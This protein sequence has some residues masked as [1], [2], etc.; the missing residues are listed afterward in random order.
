MMT[1][2]TVNH[3]NPILE[4]Q[5]VVMA[6]GLADSIANECSIPDIVGLVWELL[7]HR[8][9]ECR[10]TYVQLVDALVRD[11]DLVMSVDIIELHNIGERLRNGT[12]TRR[13]SSERPNKANTSKR[14][15]QPLAEMLDDE[16]EDEIDLDETR[17]HQLATEDEVN[18]DEVDLD[19]PLL[20]ETKE[21]LNEFLDNLPPLPSGVT[22]DELARRCAPESRHKQSSFAMRDIPP[23]QRSPEELVRLRLD[24]ELAKRVVPESRKRGEFVGIVQGRLKRSSDYP[25]EI[26]PPEPKSE[27]VSAGSKGE[28][29][30]PTISVTWWQCPLCR[31]AKGVHC[32]EVENKGT[33]Y[34]SNCK[35]QRMD[36]SGYAK[37]REFELFRCEECHAEPLVKRIDIE[38]DMRCDDVIGK[39]PATVRCGG[40]LKLVA[41]ESKDG[42]SP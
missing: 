5:V 11:L 35:E 14:W 8:R 16:E 38:S 20:G 19:D 9:F 12:T 4:L 34:C 37:A 27:R 15:Q 10:D 13:F 40:L 28:K 24:A 30:E 25:E 33:P 6:E 31:A 17:D 21:E 18:L 23:V 41:G 29:D 39:A 26:P 1:R 22:D 42:E 36:Q 32:D 7:H 3:G 2:D